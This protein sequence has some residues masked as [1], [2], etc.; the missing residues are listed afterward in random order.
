MD[1]Q[2]FFFAPTYAYFYSSVLIKADIPIILI[3]DNIF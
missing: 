2:K 3:N 1:Y